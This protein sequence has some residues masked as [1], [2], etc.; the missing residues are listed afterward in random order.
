MK[1]QDNPKNMIA[2]ALKVCRQSF[3]SLGV[4]SL[5][6]N[7]L[8]LTP[9]F[10]LINVFDKAV[11]TGSFPTLASLAVVAAFLYAVLAALEWVRSIVLVHIA[12]R[13]DHLLA[14][15][16]YDLCFLSES[17]SSELIK[18]GAAPLRDLNQL[19]QFLGG[20]ICAGLFDIPWIPLFLILMVLF[21]PALFYVAVV[22]MAI[23]A[24]IAIANQRSTTEGLDRAER[25]S[26]AIMAQTGT[27][28]RNAEVAAAMGMMK[29]LRDRWRAQQDEMLLVQAETSSVASGYTALIKTLAM[30]M[31]SVAITTGAVLVISQEISPGVMIGAALLL[32]KTL[33]PIQQVVSGWPTLIENR[34]RYGRLKSLLENSPEETEKM[35][36]PD[37][38]GHI[39]GRGVVVR[40]PGE[41]QPTLVDLNFDLAP[42]SVTMILGPS[43]AGKSTLLRAILGLWP[44][45]RGSIRIDGTES[46]YFDRDELGPQLGYLPQDIELF[47]GTV[48]ENIARFGALDSELV[49]QAAQDAHVHDLILSLPNGYD[50]VIDTQTFKLSPG[51]RQRIALARAVYGRPKIIVLDEP[52]SNLDEIGERALNQA[53]NQMK[54]LGSTI[55]LVSHRQTAMPL[56]DYIIVLAA[57]RIKEQGKKEDLVQ[58][59]KLAKQKALEPQAAVQSA[60]SANNR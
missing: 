5:F 9:M 27:N 40:P 37:V 47:D 20:P 44:T 25:M 43:A 50:T 35:S 58:R 6:I 22:C 19:R 41:K 21:H 51:Q 3:V 55:L 28:L 10:Y 45:F 60:D 30:A 13:I 46:H 29:P 7:V 36:L 17:G 42:G 4:F 48:A 12:S 31:Q 57:G 23:M 33:A 2:D 59:A 15:R 32:G 11:G 24:A 54:S 18:S 1:S 8:M 39:Q 49:V 52:N 14:S 26:A 34:E 56:V 16:I 53:I 38:R